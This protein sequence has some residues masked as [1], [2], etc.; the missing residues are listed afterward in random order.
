MKKLPLFLCLL[1][2]AACLLLQAATDFTAEGKRWWA[3]IEYL[4]SDDLK[5]RDTGSEGHLK[6]ARY[7]AGEFE[8]S[9]LKPAG[10]A[11]YFQPV[12]FDV[13]QIV[14]DESSLALVRGGKT[15]LL[16][17]GEAAN[18]SLRGATQESTAA[19]GVFA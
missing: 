10:T 17:L 2:P 8:R 9:G 1:P 7:V 4:A 12:K 13:K 19:P 15:E 18:L 6:A 3:H 14:E 5:G 11:G 16:T